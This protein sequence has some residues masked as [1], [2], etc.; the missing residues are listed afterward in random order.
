MMTYTVCW[1][2]AVSN[3]EIEMLTKKRAGVALGP[4][5]MLNC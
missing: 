2:R 5:M 4:V 1:R 3:F